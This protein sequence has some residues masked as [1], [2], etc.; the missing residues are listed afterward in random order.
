MNKKLKIESQRKDT[1]CQQLRELPAFR[2]LL[3]AVEAD[4][5]TDLPLPHPILDLGCGDGHFA[6]VAFTEKL[7]MGCDPWWSPLQEAQKR[8]RYRVLSRA[9]GAG[10][11]FPDASFATVISNSVLEHIPAVEPVIHEVARVLKPEGWFHFCVPGPNFRR[12]LSVAR[13]LE[14]IGLRGLAESYRKLFDRISRHYYYDTP[15]A[16]QARLERA[17]LQLERW[18]SYFSPGALAALEWGHP[19]GLPSVIVKKLSGRW[20]LVPQR[21]NLALTEALLRRYYEEPLPEEGAYLFFVAKK[22]GF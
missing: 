8:A 1:F 11:P 17:G 9:S 18:W 4:F 16:W 22:P 10:L 12:F 3:R 21:W 7:D 19:L 5:Y 6:S 20:L 13:G 14:A 15:E 2:A